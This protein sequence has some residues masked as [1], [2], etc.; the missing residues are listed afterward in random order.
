LRLKKIR[1]CVVGEADAKAMRVST[2]LHEGCG[3]NEDEKDKNPE[4]I[5]EL[6]YR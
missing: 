6:R 1:N 4:N 5:F 3:K 2:Y